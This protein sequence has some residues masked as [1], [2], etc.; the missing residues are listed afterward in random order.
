MQLQAQGKLDSLR[1][2]MEFDAS[3]WSI[4]VSSTRQVLSTKFS[5]FLA[6]GLNLPF[7]IFFLLWVL[8][9]WSPSF[10]FFLLIGSRKR[11][12]N[13]TN[14]GGAS[15]SKRGRGDGMGSSQL[16]NR[17]LAGLGGTSRGSFGSRGGGGGRG[18][19]GGW[20]GGRNNR[21]RDY[22]C[23]WGIL[24]VSLPC[25][26]RWFRISESDP[27]LGCY[28]PTLFKLGSFWEFDT[29]T[30]KICNTNFLMVGDASELLPDFSWTRGC[31]PCTQ[32][33]HRKFMLCWSSLGHPWFVF[34]NILGPRLLLSSG[35]LE[36]HG[37]STSWYKDLFALQVW[38]HRTDLLSVFR[39]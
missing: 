30:H 12:V 29:R 5:W 35:C 8:W 33:G 16:V 4:F 31:I 37:S 32:I 6:D 11:Q 15:A 20:R 21:N 24:F 28:L 36:V 10:T 2:R 25:T 23:A 26:I 27:L 9:Y 14:G 19:R 7:I 34:S 18:G 39:F 1:T 38:M 17:A 13:N 3:W 22:W